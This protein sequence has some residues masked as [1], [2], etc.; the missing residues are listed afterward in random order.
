VTPT[1][2]LDR[3]SSM[4]CAAIVGLLDSL[5]R[6]PDTDWARWLRHTCVEVPVI[7]VFLLAWSDN[8]VVVSSISP[9]ITRGRVLRLSAYL[10]THKVFP[11][12]LMDAGQEFR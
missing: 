2:P 1:N 9:Y 10:L 4:T 6:A 3:R 5:T 7:A 8:K 12:H 11:M